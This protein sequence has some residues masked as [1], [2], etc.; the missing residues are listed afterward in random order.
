MDH[1]EIPE[2][3][4]LDGYINNFD[5]FEE[6]HSTAHGL[7]EAK[8]VVAYTKLGDDEKTTLEVG[9]IRC[10]LCGVM[11]MPN[12]ANT[13]LMCLKSSIDITE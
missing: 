3:L 13:C 8:R 11:M 12:G 5:E 10:C 6:S 9:K 1:Y 2:H 4:D 7:S